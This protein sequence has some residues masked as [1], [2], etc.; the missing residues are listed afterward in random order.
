MKEIEEWKGLVYY[1][2][3]YV[4]LC[5]EKKSILVRIVFK[6]LVLYVGYIFNDYWY[7]GFD[8]FNNLFGVVIWFCENFVVICGDIVKM[9]YMIVIFEDD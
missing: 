7:K 2:V 6:S 3:Y 9:Y 5:L 4:V 8:F 1:V